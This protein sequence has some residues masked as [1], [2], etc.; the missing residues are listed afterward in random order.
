MY[1]CMHRYKINEALGR[2]QVEHFFSLAF[3]K[4]DV[5]ISWKKDKEEEDIFS[6]LWIGS[7]D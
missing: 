1:I 5:L 3:G 6:T 7:H 2:E 4:G